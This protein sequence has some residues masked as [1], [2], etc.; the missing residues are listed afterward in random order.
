M[1]NY[2]SFEAT[3]VGELTPLEVNTYNEPDN[4][5]YLVGRVRQRQQDV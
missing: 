3:G 1:S 2:L 4:E 5:R